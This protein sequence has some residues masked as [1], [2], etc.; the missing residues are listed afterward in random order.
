[1]IDERSFRYLLAQQIRGQRSDALHRACSKRWLD[2]EAQSSVGGALVAF[3]RGIAVADLAVVAAERRSHDTAP[4]VRG[5]G[6]WAGLARG[7]LFIALDDEIDVDD[8]RFDR[9]IADDDSGDGDGALAAADHN[10][11]TIE[12]LVAAARSLAEPIATDEVVCA[13]LLAK[14]VAAIDGGL[15]VLLDAMKGPRP[16]VVV[17]SPVNGMLAVLQ[18]LMECGKVIAGEWEY[19]VPVNNV[20]GRLALTRTLHRPSL[21]SL[22]SEEEPVSRAVIAKA[23]NRHAILTP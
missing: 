1:M 23:V 6:P 4:D 5:L 20:R 3:D 21:I 11:F 15:P 12:E 16:I 19:R 22:R 13:L 18:N 7:R 10:D 8:P 9:A 17:I 2:A 14:A